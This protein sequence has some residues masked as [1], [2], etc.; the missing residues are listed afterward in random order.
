MVTLKYSYHHKSSNDQENETVGEKLHKTNKI[1]NHASKQ[2]SKEELSTINWRLGQW[3][4]YG[5]QDEIIKTSTKNM[6]ESKKLKKQCRLYKLT[7][8]DLADK[9]ARGEISKAA[10]EQEEIV[11]KLRQKQYCLV[12][13]NRD[14]MREMSSTN[15]NFFVNKVLKGMH[16]EK[17]GAFVLNMVMSDEV[18][19]NAVTSAGKQFVTNEVYKV[20]TA[21]RLC[22]ARDTAHQGCLNLQGIEAV[23]QLQELEKTKK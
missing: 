6:K 16:F 11:E 23:R 8:D 12:K 7:V 13:K 18:F 17:Q 2:L 1:E 3:R 5:K 19:G 15:L 4:Q 9:R 22:K 14:L 10:N 21:W 20:I